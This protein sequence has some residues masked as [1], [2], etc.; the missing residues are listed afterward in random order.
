MAKMLV[1][2]SRPASTIELLQSVNSFGGGF[3]C[4][5]AMNCIVVF[6]NRVLHSQSLQSVLEYNFTNMHA[7]FY[8]SEYFACSCIVNI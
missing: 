8:R 1:S 2:I 7:M 5:T 4:Y 6:L 3:E